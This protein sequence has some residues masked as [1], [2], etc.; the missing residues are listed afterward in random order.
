MPQ[1]K[2]TNKKSH[3][4][5]H[6]TQKQNIIFQSIPN[7]SSNQFTGH[8]NNK[9]NIQYG[10]AMQQESRTDNLVGDLVGRLISKIET[11]GNKQTQEYT[12]EIQPINNTNQ[13]VNNNNVNVYNNV[14]GTTTIDKKPDETPSSDS[15]PD[16]KI[17]DSI[18]NGV[19]SAAR[20]VGEDF[21]IQAG[22]GLASIV[23]A[24]LGTAGIRNRKAI[25]NSISNFPS[26]AR[27][28]L[29]TIRE[30]FRGSSAYRP[31]VDV[32]NASVAGSPPASVAGSRRPSN[33]A[34]QGPMEILSESIGMSPAR[35]ARP[36]RAASAS[37][38][39]SEVFIRESDSVARRNR[40]RSD[41]ISSNYNTG[42][43]SE[44]FTITRPRRPGLNTE[45]RGLLE[46]T[47]RNQNIDP[48]NI[49]PIRPDV[50]RGGF[51]SS[52]RRTAVTIS[53]T[54]QTNR[55]SDT[56]RS[57]RPSGIQ[58]HDG[59]NTR[60]IR[61]ETGEPH[62]QYQTPV[63]GRRRTRPFGPQP[64]P[65]RRGRPTNAELAARAEAQVQPVLQTPARGVTRNMSNWKSTEKKSN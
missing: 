32:P 3:K 22:A 35:A 28:S 34:S 41:S 11:D 31:Q 64:Q 20:S 2:K 49:S 13:P 40:P 55:L 29:G 15:K 50:L 30:R 38:R 5:K 23:T 10:P 7:Y 45:Q 36:P 16:S 56:L 51:S 63:R 43:V 58:Q 24:A 54:P 61:A 62:T 19:K 8:Q 39:D 9:S 53:N 37:P 25:R 42:N 60:S 26:N 52:P 4:K 57:G 33:A 6:L 46:R 48:S 65:N 47:L 18:S 12:K 44:Q 59:V 14:P 17:P 27:N 1:K 21:A